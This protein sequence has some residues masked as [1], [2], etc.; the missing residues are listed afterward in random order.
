MVLVQIR[1]S[2]KL[3]KTYAFQNSRK[4]VYIQNLNC[5]VTQSGFLYKSNSQSRYSKTTTIVVSSNEINL[6]FYFLYLNQQYLF[7]TS[8]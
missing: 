4:E 7:F 8:V 2:I 5:T 6:Y 1:V 3:S